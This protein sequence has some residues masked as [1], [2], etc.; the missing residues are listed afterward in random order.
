M[1]FP[2][3]RAARPTAI[4]GAASTSFLA[5]TSE[6]RLQL[7]A[8]PRQSASMLFGSQGFWQGTA[9]EAH[10]GRRAAVAATRTGKRLRG[11]GS[12]PGEVIDV[13]PRPSWDLPGH[14]ACSNSQQVFGPEDRH[15]WAAG[16]KPGVQTGF[17]G[18][19]RVGL[20]SP[21][22]TTR[23]ARRGRRRAVGA[24]AGGGPAGG[25]R[26]RV[27]RRAS[28][29]GLPR[30]R[31]ADPRVGRAD[32]AHRADQR[33]AGA[34]DLVVPGAPLVSVL[35][36]GRCCCLGL[37]VGQFPWPLKPGDRRSTA[38]WRNAMVHVCRW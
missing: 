33:Q 36:F 19:G 24:A 26:R 30:R 25:N 10:Q 1:S 34:R 22:T 37:T 2:A 8:D 38:C 27:H 23:A 17:T 5:A 29:A 14:G 6:P 32:T 16:G 35:S 15:S 9:F 4:P 13:E 3:Q 21:A 7:R 12:S 11:G 18:P 20:C 28:S 31:G